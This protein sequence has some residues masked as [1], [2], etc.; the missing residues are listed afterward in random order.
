MEEKKNVFDYIGELFATFGIITGIFMILI[1]VIGDLASGYSSFFEYGK[2]ALSINTLFQLLCLSFIISV[3]RN[4][5]LTDRWV[6]QMSMLVRNILFFLAIVVTLIYNHLAY[7]TGQ[8]SVYLLYI[9]YAIV[10][11]YCLIYFVIL[12][13]NICRRCPNQCKKISKFINKFRGIQI[14]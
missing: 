11:P 6:R 2:Q 12:T 4:I 13:N 1:L 3:C 14:E 7:F 8:G 9:Y 10:P 5:L